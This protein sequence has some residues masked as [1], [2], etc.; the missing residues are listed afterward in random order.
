MSIISFKLF[1]KT[2]GFTLIEIMVVV[3]I[4]GILAGLAIPNYVNTRE[5]AFDKEAISGL[6]LIRAANRQYYAANDKYF[7]A[8]GTTV[9]L[10]AINGNLA[11][12]L[13]GTSWTYSLTCF[14][15]GGINATAVRNGNRTWW[16][17]NDSAEPA[18]TGAGCL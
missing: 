8:S 11:I 4:I 1:K 7:P 18:C 9:G 6:K 2:P 15:G 17:T 16:V 5:K 3:I 12:A 10:A 14:G 13:T